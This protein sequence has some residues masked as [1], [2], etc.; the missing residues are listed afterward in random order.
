[1]IQVQEKRDKD[2]KLMKEKA[3]LEKLEQAQLAEE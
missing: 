2:R 1:M 3:F